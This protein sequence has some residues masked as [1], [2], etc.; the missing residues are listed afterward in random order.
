M[1]G[2]SLSFLL[3]HRLAMENIWRLKWCST[4]GTRPNENELSAHSK[5]FYLIWLECSEVRKYFKDSSQF[6]L[7][8]FGLGLCCRYCCYAVLWC[9][10]ACENKRKLKSQRICVLHFVVKHNDLHKTQNEERTTSYYRF[11][12]QW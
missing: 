6:K 3:H 8:R 5:S 1:L 4:K 12:F 11:N 2:F 10:H 7:T 9:M